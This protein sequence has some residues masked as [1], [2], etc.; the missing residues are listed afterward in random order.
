[1]KLRTVVVRQG[2]GVALETDLNPSRDWLDDGVIR[3]LNVENATR[4]QLEQL[5]NRLGGDGKL[6]ADHITG[7]QWSHWLEREQFCVMA[8]AEPTDW[9]ETQTWFHLVAFPQT[10]VSVH[11][12]EIPAMDAFIQCRWLDRPGPDPAMEAVLLHLIQCYVEEEEDEFGRIRFQVEQHAEGLRR[13]L[14]LCQAV[15]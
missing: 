8:L 2:H 15:T 1:M 13:P 12:T 9:R 10:I 14:P 7:E 4:E 3:W 5:F 6:L 11:R